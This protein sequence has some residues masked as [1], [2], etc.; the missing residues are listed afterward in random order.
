[1]KFK[2]LIQAEAGSKQRQKYNEKTLEWKGNVEIPEPSPFPYGFILA[3]TG[4]DGGNLDCFVVTT[5]A[6]RVGQLVEC[7]AIGLMEQFEGDELEH[8]ILARLPGTE[9]EVTA[10]LCETLTQFTYK[11]FERFKNVRVQ[12][13]QFLGRDQAEA[14]IVACRD[15]S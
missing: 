13:G 5:E 9:F 2:V 12:V 4:S 14:Q 10:N 1:M 11:L 7:E 8:K 15:K 3:T 6:L